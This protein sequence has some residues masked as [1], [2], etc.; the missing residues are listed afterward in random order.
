MN[1][2]FCF[3][4]D[5]TL[6]RRELL[7]LIAA[8]VGL[9]HEFDVLT[10]LTIDGVISFEESLRLRFAILKTISIDKVQN[11]I[12]EA[13]LFKKLICFIKEQKDSCYVVT[14]NLDVW[15]S[16]LMQSIGCKYL[17]SKTRSEGDKLI[18]LDYIMHKGQ[19][20]SKLRQ[21]FPNR[22]V[23]AIGDGNNDFE[24]FEAADKSISVG[25][26]HNPSPNLIAV[27]DYIVYHEDSLCRL[28]NTL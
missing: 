4:L 10:K 15:I 23:V 19:A 18:S 14:G 2:L 3:D 27:S 25:L 8:E 17:C 24:M 11:V 20:I 21:L 26:T 13:E 28:L 16:P 7:P 12:A 22:T 5:G 1:T 9:E 6:T